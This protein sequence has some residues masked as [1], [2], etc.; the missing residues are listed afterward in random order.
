MIDEEKHK[1]WRVI[2]RAAEFAI[3]HCMPTP[4]RTTMEIDAHF[5]KNMQFK[6]MKQIPP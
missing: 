2:F 1:R 5:P 4:S 6:G 3:A